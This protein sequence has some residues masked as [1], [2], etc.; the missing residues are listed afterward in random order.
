M[1]KKATKFVEEP[2]ALLCPICQRIFHEPVISV[3]CGHTF[4]RLCIESMVHSGV[5]CPID[6]I[7]CDSTQLVLNRAV[8]GQIEDLLIYCCNGVSQNDGRSFQND[9]N[10]C[11]EMI[12]L[13]QRDTHESVCEYAH[14]VCPIGGEECGALR[15]R[16][17]ESHLSSCSRVPCPFSD[18]GCL[19][20]GKKEQVTEHKTKCVYQEESQLLAIT[21]KELKIVKSQNAEIKQ[22]LAKALKSLDK[23]T[24]EKQTMTS[25]MEQQALAITTLT[26]RMEKV[27]TDIDAFKS[28][29]LRRHSTMPVTTATLSNSSPTT[30]TNEGNTTP[31]FHRRSYSE[32]KRWSSDSA[33][34]LTSLAAVPEVHRG[35]FV[36]QMPFTLK[37]IGTFRGHKGTIWSLAIYGDRLFSSSSDGTVKVWDVADLRRGC[38]KTV[39]AHKEATMLIAVGQGI[40]YSTGTDLTLRSWTLDS[41]GELAKVENAHD[42][43]VSAMICTKEYVVTSSFASIKFWD[44]LTLNETRS[45]GSSE[46]LSHWIRA[47]VYDKRKN[48]LYSGSHNKIHVWKMGGDF[49][50]VNQTSTSYG[51]IYSLA[52]TKKYII[53]GTHNQN[54]QVYDSATLNHTST[55]TGHIGI[56][57]VLKV[58]ESPAGVYMFS[59]SSD[60]IVQVWNLENMLPIQAL[61]RHEKTVHSMALMHDTVFTG[62]EDQEI[63]VFKHFK[64]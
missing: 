44:P 28:V 54:I 43:I 24:Q 23:L 30:I 27:E 26:S 42:G 59:G 38:L 29:R 58:T 36:W 41:L 39:V 52:V 46:G 51:A 2:P 21:M 7:S 18:F 64:L 1:S 35:P 53:V 22:T 40:L 20:R 50:L 37:C 13:G 49:P 16:E 34:S 55:L 3:K 31:N 11:P 19:F 45:I 6:S 10:G 12:K 56:V 62:S 8:I 5:S 15:K 9:S 14:T 17:L 48:L 25:Q 60:S 32:M 33:T 57:T 63:K 61:Q 47:L 4:C